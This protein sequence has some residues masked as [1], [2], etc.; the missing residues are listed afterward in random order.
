MPEKEKVP[1]CDQEVEDKIMKG[2]GCAE[3]DPVRGCVPRSGTCD[4]KCPEKKR[5]KQSDGCGGPICFKP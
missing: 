2:K 1:L 4:P 3:L 5:Q